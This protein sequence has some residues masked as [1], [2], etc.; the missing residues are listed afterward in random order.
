MRTIPWDPGFVLRAVS[1]F[2]AVSEKMRA[3]KDGYVL[4][5]DLSQDHGQDLGQNLGQGSFLIAIFSETALM[6]AGG[7]GAGTWA[8]KLPDGQT[9]TDTDT[10]TNYRP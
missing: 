5:Q 7:R 1:P 10:D 9:D 2:N 3:G 8:D 4:G 6:R